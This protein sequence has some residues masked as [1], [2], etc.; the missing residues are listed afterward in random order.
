[1]VVLSAGNELST[2]HFP[3]QFQPHVIMQIDMKMKC[4]EHFMV[5]GSVARSKF[6]RCLTNIPPKCLY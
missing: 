5:D 6:K 3:Y 1:M 4:T 2:I